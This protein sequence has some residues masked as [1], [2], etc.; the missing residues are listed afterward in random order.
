MLANMKT[1][2]MEH[3]VEY[4]LPSLPEQKQILLNQIKQ[5]K[6]EGYAVSYGEKQKDSFVTPII[7]FNHKVVGALSVGLI[8]H[9]IND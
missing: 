7:G 5:I 6:N 3:I 1:N 2:E 9:R 8:S 4:L